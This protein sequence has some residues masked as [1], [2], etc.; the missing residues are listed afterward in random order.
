M[1]QPSVEITPVEETYKPSGLGSKPAF[2]I[3]KKPSSRIGG[4]YT[5][6][7]VELV[8]P[9]EVSPSRPLSFLERQKLQAQQQ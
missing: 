2:A 1:S 5:E 4:G 8:K 9:V 7:S 3:K 6:P